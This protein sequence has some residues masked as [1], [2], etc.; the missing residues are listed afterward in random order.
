MLPS[1]V[2]GR[3]R[4]LACRRG[5]AYRGLVPKLV[6][7]ILSQS[8]KSF[9]T[10]I[11]SVSSH[12]LHASKWS[13]VE[14][15]TPSA[16]RS[17]APPLLAGHHRTRANAVAILAVTRGH[18]LDLSSPGLLAA[19]PWSYP[20]H[21]QHKPQLAY[22]SRTLASQQNLG[23]AAKLRH[24]GKP[25]RLARHTPL[26]RRRNALRKANLSSVTQIQEHHHE[27]QGNQPRRSREY[28]TSPVTRKS[29]FSN[30]VE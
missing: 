15:H 14:A 2:P 16:S 30:A 11:Y 29:Q 20:P 24:N 3:R 25:T 26:T 7:I 19:Y 10:K 22:R 17:S 18:D 23:R 21:C 27:H 8:I 9:F 12:T 5:W 6:I 13:A 1:T 28:M 4:R